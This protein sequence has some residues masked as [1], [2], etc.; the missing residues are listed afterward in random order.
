MERLE[1]WGYLIVKKIQFSGVD[2]IPAY[3]RRTDRQT[4][5]QKTCDGRPI[6]RVIHTRRAVKMMCVFNFPCAL[7]RDLEIATKY[8]GFVAFGR[9]IHLQPDSRNIVG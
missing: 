9:Y 4:N 7:S 5:R 3:N 2:R 6:V 1:W 8:G